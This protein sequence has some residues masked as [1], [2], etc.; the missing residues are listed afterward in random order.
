MLIVIITLSSLL[1]ID[2]VFVRL[3]AH[4]DDRN[5]DNNDGE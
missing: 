4:N 5:N 3:N 1:A 2:I